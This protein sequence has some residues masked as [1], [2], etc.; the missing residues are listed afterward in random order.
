M[1]EIL[2]VTGAFSRAALDARLAAERHALR[3]SGAPAALL[4]LDVDRLGE[5]AQT[6]GADRADQALRGVAERLRERH[7]CWP[8]R[9]DD[10]AFV[11]LLPG[12][13]E[14]AG[15]EL[16]EIVRASI[17]IRPIAQ[18]PVT[19][20][21]GVAASP[22]GWGWD[23]ITLGA[24]ADAALRRAKSEGRNLAVAHDAGIVTPAEERPRRL[25]TPQS[26]V[27]YEKPSWWSVLTHREPRAAE[28]A[29]QHTLAPD[30]SAV[31]PAHP[32]VDDLTQ[33]L[34]R[35]ALEWRAAEFAARARQNG[36]AAALIVADLDDFTTVN[37]RFGAH[38]G[39]DV[40]RHAASRIEASGHTCPYRT[41]RDTFAV[42]LV[43]DDARRAFGVAERIRAA[44]ASAS[45]GALQLRASV[46][47][48]AAAPGSFDLAD[49]EHRALAALAAARAG[50]GDQVRLDGM[51]AA[52]PPAPGAPRVLR[53]A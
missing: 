5:I 12:G 49:A 14:H 17:V 28:P 42:L 23:D 2:D 22:P 41:E 48:A 20:S 40:L 31:A 51:P 24:R 1:P 50:G 4:V 13:D 29:P 19:V 6:Y 3:A 35:E 39:D 38:A 37:E 21:V 52:S 15:A 18:L 33:A 10:D 9:V 32:V 30:P 43:G 34:T 45:A 36:L 44:V 16:A 25:L 11:V 27:T 8:Y 7:R 53:A 46:G 47:V 26:V